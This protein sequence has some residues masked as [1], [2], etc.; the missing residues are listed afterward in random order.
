VNSLYSDL[1]I[2]GHPQP[3]GLPENWTADRLLTATGVPVL[4]IPD[5]WDSRTIGTKALVA[6]NG[7]RQARRAI[8]DAMP[9]LS[10][11]QSVT[12]LVVD[13]A[14]TPQKY[15]EEPGANISLYLTR[16]GIQVELQQTTSSGTSIAG[17]ILSKA[18]EQ[19]MDLIVIGAYS[20]GRRTE[21]LFGGV[22]RDLL[23]HA[24]IP[25]LLSR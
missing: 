25:I 2:L 8:I 6:W 5:G 24:S 21:A 19:S 3:R 7:S 13:S 18:T 14:K 17:T 15:G 10:M 22:T 20:H 1:V 4:A 16:H 23:A 12:V 9:L 11:A